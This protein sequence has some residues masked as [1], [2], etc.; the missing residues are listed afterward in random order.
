M[1]LFL[2]NEFYDA[3]RAHFVRYTVTTHGENLLTPRAAVNIARERYVFDKILEDTGG[4]LTSAYRC[5]RVN[6]LVGGDKA[7]MHLLGLAMDITP[8]PG[9]PLLNMFKLICLNS[10]SGHYGS[11]SSIVLEPS[12]VHVSWVED[13]RLDGFKPVSIRIRKKVG[14]KYINVNDK[15][16]PV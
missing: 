10:S 9:M 8:R 11:V 2:T 16:E 4:T 12:W 13:D 14:N 6:D 3:L 5:P 7:S 15:G 1:D